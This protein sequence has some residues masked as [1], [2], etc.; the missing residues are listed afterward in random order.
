MAMV[1]K[2]RKDNTSIPKKS[3]MELLRENN[4]KTFWKMFIYKNKS[5]RNL[6]K[7]GHPICGNLDL[8]FH[9]FAVT[10]ICFQKL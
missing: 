3:S 5:W 4:R 7:T 10:F 9:S 2:N 6:W 1:G 8:I